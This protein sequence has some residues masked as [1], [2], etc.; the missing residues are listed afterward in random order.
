MANNLEI[1]DTLI[2]EALMLGGHQTE[3]AVVEEALQEYV[4]RRK[5]LKILELFGEIDYD[6]DYDYKQQR[7]AG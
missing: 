7:R 5:Q 3:Q 2:Q 1:D 6:P 4:Q